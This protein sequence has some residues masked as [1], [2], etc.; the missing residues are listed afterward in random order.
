MKDLQVGVPFSAA[1][2]RKVSTKYGPAYVVES[3]GFA[4]FLPKAYSA[5][6]IRQY[7]AHRK[8]ILELEGGFKRFKFFRDVPSE[9]TFAPA[10]D[11]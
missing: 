8:F 4:C 6:D 5:V 11:E 2:I 7:D 1:V 9:T 10:A 3:D